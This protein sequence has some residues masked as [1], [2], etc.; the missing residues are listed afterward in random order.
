MKT[1]QEPT[2]DEQQVRMYNRG[3]HA[4][5]II[6]L[7]PGDK[8]ALCLLRLNAPVVPS[9][10]T[11]LKEDIEAIAGVAEISLVVDNQDAAGSVLTATSLPAN[12]KLVGVVE[13]N[14]RIEDVPPEE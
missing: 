8:Y 7:I 13:L 6:D 10:Y 9:N 2:S 5:E 12:K 3:M 14:L 11:E 4:A 1:L